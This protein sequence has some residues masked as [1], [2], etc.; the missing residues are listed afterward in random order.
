MTT[1]ATTELTDIG[2]AIPPPSWCLPG[3]QPNTESTGDGHLWSWTREFENTWI[4][5][6]DQ[7]I[8]GRVM[9]TDPQIGHE[10][11]TFSAKRAREIARDLIAA[12]DILEGSQQ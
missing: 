11:L 2:P 6:D 5:C 7:I 1:T 4:A 10:L 8:D 3:T 12:A 9:R